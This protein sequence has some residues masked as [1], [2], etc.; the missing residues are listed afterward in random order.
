MKKSVKTI[1]M[2]N[3][4]TIHS[5]QY[6]WV[7]NKGEVHQSMGIY[8]GNGFSKNRNNKEIRKNLWY[9]PSFDQTIPEQELNNNRGGAVSLANE[10]LDRMAEEIVEKRRKL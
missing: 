1:K 8:I 2:A 3:I 4:K 5:N 9:F 6:W 10:Q 7:V